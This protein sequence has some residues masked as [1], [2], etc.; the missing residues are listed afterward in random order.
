[1]KFFINN[2]YLKLLL[3]FYF[4]FFSF[5]NVMK[6]CNEFCDCCP[7]C[8]KKYWKKYFNKNKSGTEII[9]QEENN[10]E[11]NNNEEKN[12]TPENFDLNKTFEKLKNNWEKYLL[13]IFQTR[14]F[15]PNRDNKDKYKKEFQ[16]FCDQYSTKVFFE[17]L[18]KDTFIEF[19][20]KVL[21]DCESNYDEERDYNKIAFQEYTQGLLKNENTFLIYALLTNGDEN[22]ISNKI[23]NNITCETYSFHEDSKK[24]VI[25]NLIDIFKRQIIET[26]KNEVNKNKK[27]EQEII[28]EKKEKIK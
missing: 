19:S 3:I 21:N 5:K 7:D 18:T 9:N 8:C 13:E 22:N 20:K 12:I 4:S 27:I 17:S 16:D 24:S 25:S 6:G 14:L 11:E 23:F 26:I 28:S 10:E 2:C 1:M 15:P